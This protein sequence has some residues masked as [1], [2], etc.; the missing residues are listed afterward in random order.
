[1]AVAAAVAAAAETVAALEAATW[2]TMTVAVSKGAV[3]KEAAV[4]AV[5]MLAKAAAA[6]VVAARAREAAATEARKEAAEAAVV[7]LSEPQE[8]RRA[9]GAAGMVVAE[10]VMLRRPLRG[11]DRS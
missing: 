2:E 4:R 1:M 10:R 8:G 3:P 11:M 6:T 7:R 9:V 5:E